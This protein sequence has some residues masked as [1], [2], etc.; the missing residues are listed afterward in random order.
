MGTPKLKWTP[1]RVGGPLDQDTTPLLVGGGGLTDCNNLIYDRQGSWG[2]R[3]GSGTAYQWSAQSGAFPDD[4]LVSGIRWYRAYPTPKTVTVF[5]A[6][7][8]LWTAGNP[9]STPQHLFDFSATPQ[10]PI[11]FTSVRDPNAN[12]G[13]G[14]DVLV[15]CGG[16]SNTGFATD[17]LLITAGGAPNSQPGSVGQ[18]PAPTATITIAFQKN[19]STDFTPRNATENPPNGDPFQ[20]TYAILPTDNSFTIATNLCNLINESYPV[21]TNPGGPDSAGAG[22]PFLGQAYVTDATNANPGGATIHMGALFGGS[23]GNNIIYRVTYVSGANAMGGS[24]A[25]STAGS[26]VF[27]DNGG[28]HAP[29]GSPPGSQINTTYVFY[30]TATDTSPTAP[31]N[32]NGGGGTNFGPLKWDGTNPVDGLSYQITKGFTGCVTWHDHVWYWGDQADPDTLFASDIDQPEGFTFMLQEGGY[33]LGVGDGDPFIQ[34]CVPIGNT[35]Y[36]FKTSSIYA[37]NGYD[38]QSGEYAFQVAPVVQDYGIPAPYCVCVLNNALVFWTGRKFCRLQ[39]GAYEPEHIGQ[40]IP[41]AEGVVANATQS[42]VRAVAGD[43]LA[44]TKLNES[45][46]GTAP[47]PDEIKPSKAYFS[48]DSTGNGIPDSVLVYDDLATQRF[49]KY[50]WMKWTGWNVGFWIPFG[51]GPRATG[52]S[53]PP[54][55]IWMEQ[56]S[57]SFQTANEYG[58]LPDV[59]TTVPIPWMAQTGWVTC[60]T[61]ELVKNVHRVFI[62]LEATQGANGA[63]AFSMLITPA[64]T[65]ITGVQVATRFI[66]FVPASAPIGGEA[67]NI[68]WGSINPLL[69]APAFLFKFTEPGTAQASLELLAFNLDIVPEEALL[70]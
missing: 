13:N 70:P 7:G 9:G 23:S 62:E 44:T 33:D 27:T 40:P 32:W 29:P 67:Y 64:Q 35:L 49:G 65:N 5:A 10:Q 56:P 17:Y 18:N 22:N 1:I 63:P 68:L 45:F 38:F 54:I 15:I 41:D 58:L 8:S 16:Q 12:D 51:A 24:L 57:G 4:R 55:L 34:N 3:S 69:K 61:P 21:A 42:W 25:N 6:G 37:I 48:Y 50:A 39:V 11:A 36:A 19:N 28:T 14:S 20:I 47:R 2:K 30:S 31:S 26:I 60:G 53:D 59:D 46:D 66:T 52:A 43:F